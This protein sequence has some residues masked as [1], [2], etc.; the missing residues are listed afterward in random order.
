MLSQFYN[1]GLTCIRALCSWKLEQVTMSG[2]PVITIDDVIE[3]C[4]KHRKL[5][6]SKR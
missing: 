1:L 6:A 2:G 4:V 5:G 3:D